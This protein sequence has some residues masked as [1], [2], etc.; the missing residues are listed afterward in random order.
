M[1]PT[2]DGLDDPGGD[3]GVA[4]DR[5][6]RTSVTFILAT[7][8]APMVVAERFGRADVAL[9]SNLYSQVLF[10]RLSPSGVDRVWLLLLQSMV[11]FNHG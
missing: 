9:F 6:R 2:A 1:R 7:G 4:A 8:V 5:L 3:G 10:G 11:V